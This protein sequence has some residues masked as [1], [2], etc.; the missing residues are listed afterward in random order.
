MAGEKC[1]GCSIPL[2]RDMPQDA[3]PEEMLCDR[4]QRIARGEVKPVPDPSLMPLQDIGRDDLHREDAIYF[5]GL[6]AAHALEQSGQVN[7]LIGANDKVC[8]ANPVHV[9]FD[10]S[11][12]L[13]EDTGELPPFEWKRPILSGGRPQYVAWRK[14]QLW[15]IEFKDNEPEVSMD[16]SN[17]Q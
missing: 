15:E 16:D 17:H 12:F 8:I 6:M 11:A 5:L 2:G 4:C 9:Y 13:N 14:G 7:M 1:E 10:T 3:S